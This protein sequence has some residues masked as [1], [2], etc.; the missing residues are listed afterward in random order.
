MAA[1]HVQC[2][3][4]VIWTFLTGFASNLV[5]VI[6]ID[7]QTCSRSYQGQWS[8][9]YW[10]CL[11]LS[12][13]NRNW[14]PTIFKVIL[15]FQLFAAFTDAL[16]Q[17]VLVLTVPEYECHLASWENLLKEINSMHDMNGTAQMHAA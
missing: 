16:H 13:H 7:G 12:T 9:Y 6:T 4:K 14:E 15:L 5:H 11:K 2:H 8:I 10:I 3:L 1:K 17:S